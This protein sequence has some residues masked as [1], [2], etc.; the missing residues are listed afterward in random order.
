MFR[1]DFRHGKSLVDGIVFAAEKK[2]PHVPIWLLHPCRNRDNEM[3]FSFTGHNL[4][5]SKCHW[6]NPRSSEA[7]QVQVITSP[8]HVG[9]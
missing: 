5:C 9:V 4:S 6:V 1:I 8:G 7:S 3:T 2:R